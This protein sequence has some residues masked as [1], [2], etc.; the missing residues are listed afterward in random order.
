MAFTSLDIPNFR[1][2][3]NL[4]VE[5]LRR[6]NLLVGKNN[7][8]KT[9]LLEAVELL[10]AMPDVQLLFN[11]L[12][13]QRR[14]SSN[15]IRPVGMLF[16]DD[17]A[18]EPVALGCTRIDLSSDQQAKLVCVKLRFQLDSTQGHAYYPP[19]PELVGVGERIPQ[20]E[21]TEVWT[22]SGEFVVRLCLKIL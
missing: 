15:D 10:C 5:E 22:Y 4:R 18:S 2:L 19:I 11:Q 17:E 1:A 13:D 3:R 14:T 20:Q 9:S 21:Y 12:K 7:S 6:V 16:P 8:G